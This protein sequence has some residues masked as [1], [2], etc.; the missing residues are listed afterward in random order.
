MKTRLLI[1]MTVGLLFAGCSKEVEQSLSTSNMQLKS[2]SVIDGSTTYQSIDGFGFSDGWCNTLSSAK[3]N[4]L[5]NT[6][7]MNIFRAFIQPTGGYTTPSANIAAARSA[8]A[9]VFCTFWPKDEWKVS[10]TDNH[11]DSAHFADYANYIKS[12]SSP[13]DY[14]SP[15][16]EPDNVG[17]S[18]H[19]QSSGTEIRDFVKAQGSNCGKPIIV[20][21]AMSFNDSWTDPTLNDATAASKVSIIGGHIYGNGLRVHQNAIDKGKHVWQ[22][23][24]FV[25][26]QNDITSAL[27]LA[28]EV[29]DCMYNQFSAYV[30]WWV[31]DSKSENLVNNDGT[32]YKGGYVFG[33]FAKWI[34]PGKV[35]IAANYN[36][37]TNIYI[38][39]YRNNGIVIVAL[40]TGSSSVSQTFTIQN[41]SGLSLLNVHRTSSSENMASIGTIAVTNNAFTYALP[42]Q[43]VTTFHQY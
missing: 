6:I 9:T 41:I 3:N 8:G 42:A 28:K 10:S 11:L 29:S 13:F 36:P 2:A 26:N 39:A 22:T 37:A 4:A 32:I 40:N 23:E 17:G 19:S 35:R 7:G 5:Y 20:A 12:L 1:L 21:E 34:R 33:Q 14:V 31:N 18:M 24:H 25:E 15:F 38:T 43:S 30:Y 27:T 16:N